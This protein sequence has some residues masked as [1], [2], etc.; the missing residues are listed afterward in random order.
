M[1]A[2]FPIKRGNIFGKITVQILGAEI[3][4]VYF[5]KSGFTGLT[6]FI[7][8]WYSVTSIGL[9]G[10]S[11]FR[12]QCIVVMVSLFEKVCAMY[13]L[14]MCYMPSPCHTSSFI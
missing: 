11:Q 1:Q 4:N 14:S 12:F 5:V 9:L 10:S 7:V 8:V 13:F 6:D 3:R 2:I